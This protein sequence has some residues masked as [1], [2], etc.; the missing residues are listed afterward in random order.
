MRALANTMLASASVAALAVTL[1]ATTALANDTYG[2]FPIT[3]KS[4]KGDKKNSVSYTGQVARHVLHDSL[5]KLAGQG[6]GQP[7]PELK[8]KMMSYFKGEDAGRAILAPK[9]KEK[10]V[11][12]QT[13]VDDISKKKNLAGKTYKGA[14]AGM[15]NG[16]TGA[17]LV[18]FWIDKASAA[19]KGV[20]KA[21]GL[22]YPQLISKFI[23]GAVSYN[24][25]VDVYLD[26]KLNA[27]DKPN[28]KPYSDGAHYTGK[29]HAWDEGFGYFGAPAH[30]LSLTPKNVF[31]IAKQKDLAAADA[32]KDGKVDL[33]SE[34]TFGPAYYAAAFD[35]SS[36]GK[37]NATNY[38]AT[39]TRAFVD[40]R[41]L[42]ADA[43]G[44]KLTE[45]Q[46]TE[47]KK[48]ASVIA[49][50]WEKVL[51][52]AT[53]KYAGSVYNDMVKLKIIVDADGDTSKVLK[54]YIK[55]WGELK[56]F[57]LALQ[58]GK[59]NLGETATRLNRLIG[60]GPLLLNSSQVIDI[61]R[62]G[63]YVRDQSIAWGEYML[64]IVALP[65]NID[66]LAGIQ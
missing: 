54:N 44:E 39:I 60:F 1:T 4:Y 59:N 12:K 63:N 14:I 9:T 3:E 48:H 7:N 34:M 49:S 28:N 24:Q 29:E 13:A 50:N 43:K 30:T 15:P 61:D 42:I 41:K 2:P 8:A 57:S 65:V 5:K 20:D 32:N 53:Y 47:L 45:A 23:M 6:N 22:N 31:D 17:E 26:E 51:A 33:R 40:G 10:F 36:Q 11:V 52:E 64:H 18:E 56:G 35:A 58:V 46:R 38:L 27:D 66:D 25:A 21:N 16:M 37:S 62:K 55:H 19:D